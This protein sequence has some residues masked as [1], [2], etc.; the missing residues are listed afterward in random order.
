MNLPAL[1]FIAALSAMPPPQQ[2]ASPPEIDFDRA[3][4]I[5]AAQ[6][7]AE[8]LGLVLLQERDPETGRFAAAQEEDAETGYLGMM[9]QN[10]YDPG[11][12]VFMA[13]SVAQ[14]YSASD[15][16]T[17]C[18][19]SQI[20]TCSDPFPSTVQQDA[21]ITA[22]VYAGVT[23]LQRLAKAKWGVELDSGWKELL[24]WGGI[25]AVRSLFTAKNMSDANALRDL[26]R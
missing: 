9:A 18:A 26:G 14:M 22:G 17:Q 21:M 10:A 1:L 12:L 2:A 5:A 23:G 3:I 16:R 24:I 11:A 15:L 8:D 25:G 6:V 13:A 4:A 20:V 7:V 19:E